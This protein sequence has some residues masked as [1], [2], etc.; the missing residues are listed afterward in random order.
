MRKLLYVCLLYFVIAC[1]GDKKGK[2]TPRNSNSVVTT[3]EEVFYNDDNFKDVKKIFSFGGKKYETNKKTI[4]IGHIFYTATILPN[5]YYIKKNLKIKNKDS[6]QSYIKRLENEK[7]IQFDFQHDEKKDL[8]L[9]E[10]TGVSYKKSVEYLSSLI[11]RDFYAITSSGDSI[12]SSGVLFERSFNLT[13]RK[14]ILLYFKADKPSGRL[15][16]IYDDKIF[17]KGIIKFNLEKE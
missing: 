14:R 16:L 8:L 10:Y 4:K 2:G 7:I 15:K 12:K 1:Q 11:Q 6:V 5:E 3:D 17:R 13:P 9:P